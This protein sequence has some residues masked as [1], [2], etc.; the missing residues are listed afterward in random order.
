MKKK[1]SNSKIIYLFFIIT[2]LSLTIAVRSQDTTRVSPPL[3]DEINKIVSASCMPCHSAKGGMMARS[4]LNFNDWT[5]Y[6]AEKQKGKANDIYK[7]VSND[8]MPPKNA[9]ENNPGI[10]PTKEQVSTI[11]KWV[12]TFGGQ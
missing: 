8:K 7:E 1:E 10:I 9:R 2:F 12:D 3:P 6:P 4:K 11:K 5:S